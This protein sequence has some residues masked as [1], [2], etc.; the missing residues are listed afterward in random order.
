MD[1]SIPLFTHYAKNVAS[2][3]MCYDCKGIFFHHIM[4][5][6]SMF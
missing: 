1:K 2:Q 3:R 6:H 5:S 4:V